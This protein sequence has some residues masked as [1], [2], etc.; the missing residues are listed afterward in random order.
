M[1]IAPH[2]R[3]T[4]TATLQAAMNDIG[5]A[6]LVSAPASG[7][8]VSHIPLLTIPQPGPPNG[9]LIGHVARANPHWE[10]ASGE[11]VVAIFMGPNGYISPNWY[12]TKRQTGKAVPTWNYIAIHAHGTL[13]S[14]DDP[15][16]LLDIVTRLTD[17][18]EARSPQPWHVS[19][20]P[21]DYIDSMLKA[22][23]GVEIT[24]ERIEGKY[25]LNQ[26]RPEYDHTGALEGLHARGDE[27]SAALARAMADAKLRRPS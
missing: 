8:L 18:Y 17:R 9:T 6:T 26:N 27:A 13:R 25:K 12:E 7:I 1:Y 16:R 14:F 10:A 22:I 21:A 2:N 15:T 11:P 23:I 5:F 20:A 24:I 19:D 3:E 4:D